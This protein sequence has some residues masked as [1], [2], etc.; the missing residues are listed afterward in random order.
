MD[1]GLI[2]RFSNQEPTVP[3]WPFL[4][5]GQPAQTRREFEIVRLL[6]LLKMLNAGAGTN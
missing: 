6:K 5:K 2:R 3:D 1:E 4:L